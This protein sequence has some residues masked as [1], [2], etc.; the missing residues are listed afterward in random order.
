M[1]RAIRVKHGVFGR[2]AVLD[3]DQ[4][5]VVHAHS[6]AHVLVKIGGAD[7][8]FKLGSQ[9][10][11]LTQRQ[12]VVIDAWQPHA[13]VQP[14]GRERTL[15]LAFYLEQAWLN[16][17]R[18]GTAPRRAIRNASVAIDERARPLLRDLASNLILG[19]DESLDVD[20]AIIGLIR[21]VD[22]ALAGMPLQD[23]NAM[24]SRA[25]PESRESLD[26]RLEKCVTFMKEN[27]D[28]RVPLKDVGSRFGI[29]RPHL[30]HLFQETFNMAP[31]VYWNAL[32]MQYAIGQLQTTRSISIGSIAA[33]LGF[34]S[35]ANFTR[36]FRGI[37]GVCPRDYQAAASGCALE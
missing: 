24:A 3:M 15:L 14:S 23:A 16:L 19:S 10:L 26:R 34:V 1:S 13:Y 27:L 30:F 36:F 21:F 2:I 29:S 37:Q 8:H 6:Q 31:G 18:L 32:R 5:L 28:A 12:L 11:A 33:D 17:Q 9:S 22:A 7:A 20:F 4:S 25:S 35:Q